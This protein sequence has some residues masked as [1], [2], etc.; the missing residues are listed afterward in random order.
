[1]Y[2]TFYL[3]DTG[4][5]IICRKMS[6]AQAD[7]RIARFTD[8]AYISEFCA[9]VDN[10]RVDLSS[11]TLVEDTAMWQE[12]LNDWLRQ[13]R[14]LKLKE[15]DWTQGADSPLTT[16]KKTEWATY[17]QALRDLPSSYPNVTDKSAIT[18]PSKPD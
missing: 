9:N 7:D 5:I 18:W 15:S 1:M 2:K 4:K 17:R 12:N 16:S 8:Q 6:D 3:K 11:L 13:R 14:N 10:Y